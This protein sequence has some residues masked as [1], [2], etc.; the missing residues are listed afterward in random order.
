[1]EGVTYE[2]GAFNEEIL[3]VPQPRKRVQK[4]KTSSGAKRKKTN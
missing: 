3:S 2:S 4:P 1:M